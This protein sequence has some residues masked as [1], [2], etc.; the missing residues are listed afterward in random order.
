MNEIKVNE[1]ISLSP[2]TYNDCQAMVEYLSEKAI[3]DTTLNIP[4]PY[5]KAD[6]VYIVNHFD[7]L[8]QKQGKCS[9]WA[10]RN[11]DKKLIG[12]IGFHGGIN[13]HKSEIGYW[14]AKPFWGKSI[15]TDVLRTVCNI[16]FQHTIL[17]RITATIFEHNI[18]SQKVLEKC[19]FVLEANRLRNYYFKDDRFIDAK[20]YALT[21]QY[22]R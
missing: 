16:S 9:N 7:M 3:Y 11:I 21:K 1:N 13:T 6:A 14:L 4:H 19:N 8:T 12:V 22:E 10:I 5:S 15:M 18:A 17:K 20:L 2:T